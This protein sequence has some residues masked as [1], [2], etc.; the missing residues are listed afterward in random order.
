MSNRT[1][2]QTHQRKEL[3]HSYND[4]THAL[5]CARSMFE[6]ISFIVEG[7]GSKE[8][9]MNLSSI[10]KDLC[11]EI[12]QQVN[13]LLEVGKVRQKKASEGTG[14]NEPDNASGNGNWIAPTEE[15]ERTQADGEQ[16]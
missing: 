2:T 13:L 16:M 7:N 14:E 5:G 4:L 15:P 12:H 8:T 1:S 6:A 11:E 3:S 10:G 9:L